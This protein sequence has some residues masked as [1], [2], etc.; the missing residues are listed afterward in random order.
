MSKSFKSSLACTLSNQNFAC[1]P[2]LSCVLHTS[3]IS[4]SLI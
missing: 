4:S 3:C 1:T 2:H